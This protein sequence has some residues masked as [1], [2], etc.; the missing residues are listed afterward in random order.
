[1]NMSYARNFPLYNHLK[2]PATVTRCDFGVNFEFVLPEPGNTSVF[3][4]WK[5]KGTICHPNSLISM[6]LGTLVAISQNVK[7]E[8]KQYKLKAYQLYFCPLVGSFSK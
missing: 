2:V 5:S 7:I 1:M 8:L 6:I 4:G 3:R